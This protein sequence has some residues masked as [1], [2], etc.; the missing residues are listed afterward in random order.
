VTPQTQIQINDSHDRKLAVVRSGV[1]LQQL[2][3]RPER[4]WA[5]FR[6]T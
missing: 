6:A 3:Q 2:V 1:S 4:A 5:S